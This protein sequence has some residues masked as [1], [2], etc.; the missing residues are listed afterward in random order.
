[1][2]SA[3]K[4]DRRSRST[5]AGATVRPAQPVIA[6]PAAH[7]MSHSCGKGHLAAPPPTE[8]SLPWVAGGRVPTLGGEVGGA[9]AALGRGG[10]P[11]SRAACPGVPGGGVGSAKPALDEAGTAAA[12]ARA[13]TRGA[14]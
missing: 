10:G 6:R 4:P 14:V 3:T 12:S 2:P 13:Y 8:P 5:C 9:C 11:A 7:G 1:T